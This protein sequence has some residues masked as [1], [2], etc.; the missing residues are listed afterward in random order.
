[1]NYRYTLQKGSKHTI[2]PN[3][4]KK[5]FKPYV[6]SVTGE[7]VGSERFQ[8]K[9]NMKKNSYNIL[10][11]GLFSVYLQ[12]IKAMTSTLVAKE[13]HCSFEEGKRVDAFT[14]IGWA[15]A[16]HIMAEKICG[17]YKITSPSKRIYIGQSVDIYNRWRSH[18]SMAC[19]K[20]IPILHNSMKKY[21]VKRHKFEII[22]RCAEN[23]LNDYEKFFIDLYDSTGEKGMNVM[24][25]GQYVHCLAEET[26]EKIRQVRIE[27]SKQGKHT[28]KYLG[29]YKHSDGKKWVSRVMVKRQSIFMGC[30]TKEIDAAYYYDIAAMVLLGKDAHTNFTEEERVEISKTVEVCSVKMRSSKYM[31]VSKKRSS[32]NTIIKNKFLGSY[33][34]E[35]SAA[36]AYDIEAIKMYG[37]NCKTNF[38]KEE[39]EILKTK[40]SSRIIRECQS[41]Y[42]G[43]YRQ[44]KKWRS[45]ITINYK[46][47]KIGV[48]DTEIEAARAFNEYILKNNLN[49]KLNVIG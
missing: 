12:D 13:L 30:F 22:A 33:K 28:S 34:D 31:G 19:N 27:E 11:F 10:M 4:H 29:V 14:G 1:M 35:V 24:G 23:E 48:Y 26:K 20:E 40:V 2:C 15:I 47:I 36:Y 5:T 18:R 39:R 3:C 42:N 6:D 45:C 17:I 46:Q 37:E 44:G 16:F 9:I 43:V 49:R 38:T 25:G 7:V 41:K 8:K 21:G 32:W